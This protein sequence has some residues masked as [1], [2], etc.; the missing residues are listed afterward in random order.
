MT[1]EIYLDNNA[2]TPVSPEVVEAMRPFWGE[3]YG[4]P[5]SLH[6]KG[7]G[8][9]RAVTNVRYQLAEY[10][11]VGESEVVF[12]SGATEALNTAILGLARKNARKG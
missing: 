9:E 8:A 5:S 11:G 4:N 1:R 2:T 3:Q 10:L 12:T 7:V 6:A